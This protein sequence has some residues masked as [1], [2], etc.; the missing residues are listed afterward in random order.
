MKYNTKKKDK[1][2]FSDEKLLI[3]A[4]FVISFI[5][6]FLTILYS[7]AVDKA[8]NNAFTTLETQTKVAQFISRLDDSKII[9][10]FGKTL[11]VKNNNFPRLTLQQSIEIAYIIG[12]EPQLTTST[13]N[14]NNLDDFYKNYTDINPRV[15]TF[16]QEKISNFR[17]Y[18]KIGNIFFWIL[19]TLQFINSLLALRLAMLQSKF[20]K[21]KKEEKKNIN[22]PSK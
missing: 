20:F 8:N 19:V 22:K 4:I 5:S 2:I 3:I 15:T 11:G 14:I 21:K 18:T 13:N 1:S 7:R 16:L 6:V 10:E 17:L 12:L 9:D